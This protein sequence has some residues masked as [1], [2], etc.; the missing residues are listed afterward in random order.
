LEHQAE[1]YFMCLQQPKM[2]MMVASAGSTDVSADTSDLSK[3]RSLSEFGTFQ[4]SLKVK[5]LPYFFK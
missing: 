5:L 4:V 3:G 2:M 1:A